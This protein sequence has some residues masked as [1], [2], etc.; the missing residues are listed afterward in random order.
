M[1]YLFFFYFIFVFQMTWEFMTAPAT[2][3]DKRK[4]KDLMT[5]PL[6]YRKK[7]AQ[8]KVLFEPHLNYKE[9]Y[10]SFVH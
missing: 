9:F 10:K 1:N 2:C 8:K 4:Y 6:F 7:Q 5:W 3:E